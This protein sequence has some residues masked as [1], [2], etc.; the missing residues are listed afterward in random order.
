MSCF[1]EALFEVVLEGRHVEKTGAGESGVCIHWHT[2][3]HFEFFRVFQAPARVSWRFVPTT[4]P[5]L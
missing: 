2:A 4:E 3:S 1:D 5:G